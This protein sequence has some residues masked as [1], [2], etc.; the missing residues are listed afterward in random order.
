MEDDKGGPRYRFSN[1]VAHATVAK[2][3]VK[4]LQ[5]NNEDVSKQMT[6]DKP[7]LPYSA[8]FWYQ[9]AGA[10][11][12]NIAFFPKLREQINMIFSPEYSKSYLNWLKTYDYD[13]GVSFG[14]S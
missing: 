4:Y 6:I 10:V 12:D 2:E 1:E 9:H 11:G 3:T 14:Y 5:A 13:S 8:Q 7:L